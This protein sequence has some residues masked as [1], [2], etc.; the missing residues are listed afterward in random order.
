MPT[1]SKNWTF[2]VLD[3][4]QSY[5]NG[6]SH[7]LD[8]ARVYINGQQVSA[9][10]DSYQ[11]HG[12]W[13]NSSKFQTFYYSQYDSIKFNYNF[14]KPQSGQVDEYKVKVV[15]D[16]GEW[17]YTV[18]VFDDVAVASR[19]ASQN[20]PVSSADVVYQP[21]NELSGS[22]SDVGYAGTDQADHAQLS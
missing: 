11:Y 19:H 7:L 6:A 18:Y 1:G 14:S 12:G 15:A 8:N 5:W 20:L 13:S 9:V 4:S 17:E 16:G 3:T 10:A 21:D 22:V 2:S